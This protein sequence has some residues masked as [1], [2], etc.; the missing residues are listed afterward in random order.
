MEVNNSVWNAYKPNYV[1]PLF[2]PYRGSNSTRSPLDLKSNKCS[3]PKLP[4]GQFTSGCAA[5][6]NPGLV[7]KNHGQTF[8]LLQSWKPCPY[9][10]QKSSDPKDIGFC[11]REMFENEP[12][13]YTEKNYQM[14]SISH[15]PVTRTDAMPKLLKTIDPPGSYGIKNGRSM[16]SRYRNGLSGLVV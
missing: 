12:V 11:F 3:V 2:A 10:W 7:A 8:R 5:M 9:G 14:T 6:V 15:Y 1:D 13:F 4:A 16:Y